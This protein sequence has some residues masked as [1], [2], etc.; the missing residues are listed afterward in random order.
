MKDFCILFFLG[1]AATRPLLA[2]QPA[3][4]MVNEMSVT[5]ANHIKS[6]Y[7]LPKKGEQIAEQFLGDLK[8]GRFYQARNLKKLDSIMTKSLR[9]ASNDFHLY[10]WNNREIV[11]QLQSTAEDDKTSTSTNFFNN[12]EAYESNFGF[13]V[14]EILPGNI[15]YIRLSQINISDHS[16]RKLYATMTLVENTKALIIDLRNNSG[17]G[18]TIGSVLETYFFE[19]YV[20]LLEFRQRNG[21]TELEGTV[22]WLLEERYLKP[23]YLLVNKGTASAAEAFA[24]GLK[25][26]NRCTIIG[27][28]TSGG[29]YMNSYFPVNE[30]FVVAIS[31]AAPFLP[32]TTESWEATGVQPDHVVDEKEALTKALEIIKSK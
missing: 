4:K 6:N 7:V 3:K 18:S 23:L 29:A 12:K 2:Q 9:E 25:H 5:I 10:T 19:A 27:Q 31:T 24:F 20:P 14:V 13:E 21:E 15:G 30:D 32:G 28:P 26:H 11:R 17:G 8:N 22:G 1:V 16:L